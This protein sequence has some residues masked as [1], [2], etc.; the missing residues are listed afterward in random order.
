[1]ARNFTLL[2]VG[3]IFALVTIELGGFDILPGVLGYAIVAVAS[4]NLA[5][6]ATKFQIARNLA[7]P[8][9][10]LSLLTYVT[11]PGVRESLLLISAILTIL[12]VWFVLGAVIQFT[13][14]R[15][16]MDLAKHGIRYR[17]IYVGIAA[18]AFLIQLATAVQPELAEGFLGIMMV[19]TIGILIFILRLIYVVRHDL[20]IEIGGIA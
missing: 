5:Q 14:E 11:P 15:D 19:A 13:R 7:L 10:V 12:L 1:M 4:Y 8:L 2:M 18:F 6:Y 3:L 9:V 17:R 20:V 16:R